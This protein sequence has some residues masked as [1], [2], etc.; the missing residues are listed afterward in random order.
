MPTPLPKNCNP[1]GYQ[2]VLILKGDVEFWRSLGYSLE[3]EF[4]D[5]TDDP[6]TRLMLQDGKYRIDTG[7]NII[8]WVG[9]SP[10]TQHFGTVRISHGYIQIED[11]TITGVAETELWISEV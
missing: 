10:N 3:G 11:K 1:G 5:L 4:L 8:E 6:Q 9:R 2:Q 7:Q